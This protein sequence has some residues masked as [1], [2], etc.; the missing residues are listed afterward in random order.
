M[1]KEEKVFYTIKNDL[2]FKMVLEENKKA[3]H[4]LSTV[5]IEDLKGDEYKP[6]EI[7]IISRSITNLE[8]M[9]SEMDVCFEIID[10][11]SFDLEM[12]R[13]KTQYFLED[14]ILKYY[15]ELVSH[16][17]PKGSEYIHN[18]CHSLWFLDFNYFKDSKEAIHTYKIKDKEGSALAH[19]GSIT[20]VEIKKLKNYNKDNNPWFELF[21]SDNYSSIKGDNVLEEVVNKVN[22]L[23]QDEAMRFRLQSQERFKTEYNAQMNGAYKNGK[24]EGMAEGMAE[25]IGIGEKKKAMEMAHK[26]IKIGM[27]LE[28]VSSVTG[29]SVEEIKAL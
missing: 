13:E 29:L 4:K 26:L 2:V 21:Y 28:D 23:N 15:S 3:L 17:Y 27:S 5:F 12:Q 10:K 11:Y 24:A 8:Y 9:S 18:I 7:K 20:I 25:G 14:R 19:S 1:F 22:E 6:D 16:S